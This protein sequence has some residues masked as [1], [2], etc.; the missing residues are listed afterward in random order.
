ML[1]VYVE[2]SEIP[3]RFQKFKSSETESSVAED[4]DGKEEKKVS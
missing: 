1:E 4:T 3:V 2:G